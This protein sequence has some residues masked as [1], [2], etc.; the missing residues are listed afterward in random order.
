MEYKVS[1]VALDDIHSEDHTFRITTTQDKFSLRESIAKLGLLQ[2]PAVWRGAS[3]LIVV[4][5][6]RR[7]SA[8][9]QLGMD[10]LP[11]RLV[12]GDLRP[13]DG[14]RMAVTE[15]ITQRP[16]NLVEMARAVRR[17][18]TYC[19]AGHKISDELALLGLPTSRK[20]ISKLE[21]LGRLRAELQT[22]VVDGL[23]GLNAAL[24]IGT[25]ARQDQS[26]VHELFSLLRMSVSKQKEVLAMACDIAG[27]DRKN[28]CEVL[29]S[30]MVRGIVDDDHLDRN[31]KTAMIRRHLKKVRYPHLTQAEAQYLATV[32]SLKLGPHM[33]ID[34][35]AHFEG[36]TY[37]LSL[38]FASRDDLEAAYHT[39]GAVLQN[40]AVDSIFPH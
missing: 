19:P 26:A 31:Q 32:R 40:P 34:P 24:E 11:A 2:P 22:A 20:M 14:L 12:A 33:R 29:Q 35:P 38:R 13:W 30:D 25:M 8:C 37:T 21:H 16:L 27:R 7:I 10:T 28:L 4:S 1:Q 3:G 36:S 6:F 5:G 9:R 18:K 15:N 39:I 17:V 23:I